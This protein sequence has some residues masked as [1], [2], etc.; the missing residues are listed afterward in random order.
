MLTFN[1]GSPSAMPQSRYNDL[2]EEELVASGYHILSR[3]TQGGVNLFSKKMPSQFVFL[4]GHP[5]YDETTLGR[6]YLR[7]VGRYLNGEREEKPALPENYFD[8]ATLAALSELRLG[9]RNPALLPRFTEI[10]SHAVPAQSWRNDAV[11]LFGNWLTLVAAE[12]ARR[13]VQAAKGIPL[14]KLRRSA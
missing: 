6:E 11:A 8:A 13:R 4:Q 7:D 2:P 3:L 5:E 14:A 12:K 1:V 10:V 9:I